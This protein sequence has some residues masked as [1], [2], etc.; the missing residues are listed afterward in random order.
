MIPINKAIEYLGR[1]MGNAPFE[2]DRVIA[3]MSD[4]TAEFAGAG[5]E[6]ARQP[7]RPMLA[8][9][10]QRGGRAGARTKVSGPDDTRDQT[11]G[12]LGDRETGTAGR[13]ARASACTLMLSSHFWTEGSIAVKGRVAAKTAFELRSIV[14]GARLIIKRPISIVTSRRRRTVRMEDAIP[15]VVRDAARLCRFSPA[16]TSHRDR[17]SLPPWSSSQMVPAERMM[18]SVGARRMFP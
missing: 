6:I 14:P 15:P 2:A 5:H 16:R 8:R 17:N 18:K 12:P 1:C 11:A 10:G 13:V 9:E 4:S 7:A 3:R